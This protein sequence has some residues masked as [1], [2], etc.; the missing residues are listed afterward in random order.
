MEERNPCKIGSA[1]KLRRNTTPLPHFMMESGA[2]FRIDS[3]M[4]VDD[5][6]QLVAVKRGPREN[7]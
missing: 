4:V 5:L 3:I 2:L 6:R 7:T 1:H